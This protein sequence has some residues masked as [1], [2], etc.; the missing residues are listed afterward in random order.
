ME[1][2]LYGERQIFHLFRAGAAAFAE[3]GRAWGGD[4]PASRLGLLRDVGIGLRLGSSR[5]SHG[6]MVHVD[7]AYP[8]DAPGDRRRPQLLISTG[9]TF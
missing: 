3:V 1:Q 7:L 4:A 9:D 6:A 5:S 8:L 2:R